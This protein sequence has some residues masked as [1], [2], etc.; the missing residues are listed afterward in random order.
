MTSHLSQSRHMLHQ[1]SPG[2][3]AGLLPG[4][5]PA[6][7]ATAHRLG[8]SSKVGVSTSK[9]AMLPH[10]PLP[11]CCPCSCPARL[12]SF[13]KP[14]PSQRQW[15]PCLILCLPASEV[16]APGVNAKASR[17]L[18]P[19]CVPIWLEVLKLNNNNVS[20][21]SILHFPLPCT[22]FTTQPSSTPSCTVRHGH[23]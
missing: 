9:V 19:R 18:G 14:C 12:R 2:L 13:P 10:R 4:E 23:T 21:H 15:Q 8:S 6:A 20:R 7:I 1:Q 11:S 5:D 22:D 3:A 16:W 17:S